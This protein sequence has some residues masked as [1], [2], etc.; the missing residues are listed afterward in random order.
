MTRETAAVAKKAATAR[1][2]TLSEI[3]Q[4]IKQFY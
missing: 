1:R 2:Y 3:L 4:T